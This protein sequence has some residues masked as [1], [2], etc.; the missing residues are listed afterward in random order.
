MRRLVIAA[1]GASTIGTMAGAAP[2]KKDVPA[3]DEPRGEN[4]PTKPIDIT[5][6]IDKLEVFRDEIGQFYTSP[7]RDTITSFEDAGAFVF[8]GDGKK[9]YRQRVYGSSSSPDSGIE[10]HVWSPRSKNRNG[11]TIQIGQLIVYCSSHGEKGGQK[12][13]V[14]LKADEAKALLTHATFL[15]PLFHRQG[16]RLARDDDAVYYYIDRLRDEF[17]GNGYRIFI[18]PAGDLKPQQ[19]T[20]IARD[21]A[22]EIFATKGG[23]MKIVIKD[24]DK[25]VQGTWVRGGKRVELTMLPVEDNIYLIYRDFGLY[26]ALGTPCDDM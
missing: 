14:Q 25:H 1:L 9:M 13:L 16:H 4:E 5:P 15:P 23:Q 21:S 18:G 26:G 8:V 6:A 22:G 19:M 17:G 12:K 20:N 11:A 7:R 10:W 3:P 2:Q 24:D